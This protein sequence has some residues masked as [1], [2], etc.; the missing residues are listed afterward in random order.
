[1]CVVRSVRWLAVDGFCLLFVV[2]CLLFAVHCLLDGDWCVMCVVRVGWRSVVCVCC[3]LSGIC[4]LL[5]VGRGALFVV[6]CSLPVDVCW[7]LFVVEC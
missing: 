5:V 6:R 7:L 2:W 3:L 4:C 1:M